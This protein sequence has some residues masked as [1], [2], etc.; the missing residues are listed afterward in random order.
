MLTSSKADAP[1]SSSRKARQI[2]CAASPKGRVKTDV[3]S[4]RGVARLEV[5]QWPLGAAH[6]NPALKKE[7]FDDLL[8]D[9][10]NPPEPERLSAVQGA[11]R[12]TPRSIRR[13]GV[14]QDKS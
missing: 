3:Q 10:H 8:I 13:E 11:G 6:G 7:L 2:E 4:D 9:V 1:S 12:G 14:E 5:P